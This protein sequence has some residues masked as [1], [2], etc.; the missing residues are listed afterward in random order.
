MIHLKIYLNINEC[1]KLNIII[2]LII[3]W[4]CRTIVPTWKV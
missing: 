2:C 1:L 4:F 3:G